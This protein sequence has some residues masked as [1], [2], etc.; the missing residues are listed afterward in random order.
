MEEKKQKTQKSRILAGRLHYRMSENQ[1]L[2]SSLE[3]KSGNLRRRKKQNTC[4]K[5][6]T[7]QKETSNQNN[8]TTLQTK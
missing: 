2:D 3:G 8:G 6:S 4:E 7:R 5:Q 1:N